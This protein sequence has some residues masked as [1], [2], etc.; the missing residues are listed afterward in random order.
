M[1]YLSHSGIV[2]KTQIKATISAKVRQHA[3]VAQS[4]ISGVAITGSDFEHDRHLTRLKYASALLLVSRE[5]AHQ[6]VI[7][8]FTLGVQIRQVNVITIFQSAAW[9]RLSGFVHHTDSVASR[10][11]PG[12]AKMLPDLT[13]QKPMAEW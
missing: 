1:H 4:H 6:P 2:V 11:G 3:L 12:T 10:S 5:K 8:G 13:P 7:V 9:L